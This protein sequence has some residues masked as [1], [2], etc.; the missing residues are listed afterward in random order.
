MPFARAA[1]LL[2]IGLAAAA[3][4]ADALD[5]IARLQSGGRAEQALAVAERALAA[6]PRSAPLRFARGVLLADLQRREEAMATFRALSQDHPELAEPHNNLAVLLAA[7]GEL[8]AARGALEQALRAK[9]D[10]ATAFENLGDIHAMLAA[11]AYAQAAA[12]DTNNRSAPAKLQ[13]AR[14]V[15]A[16]P[17]RP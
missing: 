17:R 8:D 1:A 6:T 2:L 16:P 15:W 14:G 12:L 5:D 10:Y 3:A 4:R 11:R 7:K 13:L 9:P